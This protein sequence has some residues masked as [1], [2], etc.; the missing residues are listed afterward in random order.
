MPFV[1]S[2][3]TSGPVVE[4]ADR[5][6]KPSISTGP[7]ERLAHLD[8]ALRDSIASEAQVCWSCAA[9]SSSTQ[10]RP[11]DPDEF[12]GFTI[13]DALA[14]LVFINGADTKAAQTFT[15]AHELAHLWIGQ[16]GVTDATIRQTPAADRA[17]VQ[18]G[19]G[20]VLVRSQF[21]G[22]LQKS[23]QLDRESAV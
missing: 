1:G 22:R 17:L 19:G 20:R 14:P 7:S 3:T 8:R 6:R 15:L 21:C 23:N 9:A 10:R 5:M 18:P 2:V 12:R 11:L 4:V 13:A 16:S